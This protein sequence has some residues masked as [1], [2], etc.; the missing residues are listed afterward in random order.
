MSAWEGTLQI[1]VEHPALGTGWNQPESLYEH[2]Y[3]LPKVDESAAITLNDYLML[4]ATLGV[5]ALICFIAYVGLSLRQNSEVRSQKSA[6]IFRG[7]GT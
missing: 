1:M 7:S 4:G 2:Y 6:G 3:L 5:P